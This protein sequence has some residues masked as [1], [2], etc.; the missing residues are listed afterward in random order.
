MRDI[1]VG[2]CSIPYK[3]LKIFKPPS[4]LWT[5]NKNPIYLNCSLNFTQL[6][7]G[8]RFFLLQAHKA[9]SHSGH[10]VRI[11]R[12]WVSVHLCFELNLS[13]K[14][15]W[16]VDIKNNT[17]LHKEE[18]FWWWVPSWA[19]ANALSPPA[20]SPDGGVAFPWMP[21]A[22]CDTRPRCPGETAETKNKEL[23]AWCMG[24]FVPKCCNRA[25]PLRT[26]EESWVGFGD[27]QHINL[28]F[29]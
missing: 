5:A 14:P 27:R 13:A 16:E 17:K 11:Y 7:V 19:G 2:L 29:C 12:I 26:S 23:Q 9:E 1:P 3:P 22:W 4:A 6:N 28:A 24:T 10:S 8:T 20:A 15:S 21:S 25:N 18:N